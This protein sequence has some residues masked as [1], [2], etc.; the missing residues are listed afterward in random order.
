MIF[1][2]TKKSVR[3]KLTLCYDLMPSAVDT[4]IQKGRPLSQTEILL[5]CTVYLY[6]NDSVLSHGTFQS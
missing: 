6:I 4:C 3:L 2:A 5:R 1:G